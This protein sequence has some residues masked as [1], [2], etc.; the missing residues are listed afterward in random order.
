LEQVP[1]PSSHPPALPP[2][3]YPPPPREKYDLTIV[4]CAR[5]HRLTTAP[6]MVP[7]YEYCLCISYHEKAKMKI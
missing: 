3:R 2:T 6:V 1:L 7:E 4:V 5:T